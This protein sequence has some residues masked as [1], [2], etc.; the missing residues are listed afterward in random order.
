[1]D[2]YC[3]HIISIGIITMGFRAPTEAVFAGPKRS[4]R[5]RWDAGIFRSWD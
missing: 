2:G 3:I 5:Y 1:M 4:L